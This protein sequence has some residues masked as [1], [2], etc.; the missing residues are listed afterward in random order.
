[1]LLIAVGVIL[2]LAGSISLLPSITSASEVARKAHPDFGEV[3]PCADG[4]SATFASQITPEPGSPV[5]LR[6][7]QMC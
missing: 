5:P 2:L 1:L 3:L 6:R 4:D 7:R